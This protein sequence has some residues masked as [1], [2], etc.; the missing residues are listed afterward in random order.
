MRG[1]RGISPA[2]FSSGECKLAQRS[3]DFLL[4]SRGAICI[5][6]VDGMSQKLSP[7]WGRAACSDTLLNVY[8]CFRFGRKHP[9]AA[10]RRS[11]GSGLTEEAGISNSHFLEVSLNFFHPDRAFVFALSFSPSSLSI[12][13]QSSLLVYS[14]SLALKQT[15]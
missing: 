2:R 1:C 13:F 9:L 5:S 10:P 4:P 7:L 6:G 8:C 14:L 15:E 3:G 12:L 11:Y